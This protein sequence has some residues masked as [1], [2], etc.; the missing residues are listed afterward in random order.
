MSGQRAACYQSRCWGRVRRSPC[1]TTL[2]R[3]RQ[4]QQRWVVSR[5]RQMTSLSANVKRLMGWKG[6]R[7]ARSH[8]LRLASGCVFCYT[9]SYCF[10][11]HPPPVIVGTGQ[12]NLVCIVVVY[13][14]SVTNQTI[15]MAVQHQPELDALRTVIRTKVRTSQTVSCAGMS[16]K[17]IHHV[18]FDDRC[19]GVQHLLP[20][21]P[22]SS[23]FSNTSAYRSWWSACC[24]LPW[25]AHRRT[26]L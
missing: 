25:C 16:S 9:A 26:M 5:E 10:Y 12:D 6:Q 4:H 11:A 7:G 22:G 23:S 17:P 13:H 3:Q 18:N 15:M 14:L 1:Q 21:S 20:P 19:L 24:N 8:R 2:L